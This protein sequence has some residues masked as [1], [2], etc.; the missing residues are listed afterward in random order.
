MSASDQDEYLAAYA[1][2]FAGGLFANKA[3]KR[4]ADNSDV[5][6]AYAEATVRELI[7]KMVHPLR[8]SRGAVIGPDLYANPKSVRQL[9]TIIWSPNPLP[10]IFESGDFALVPRGG[11]CGVIEVKR[12]TYSGA[13]ERMGEFLF[14][15]K[16]LVGAGLCS[17]LRIPLVFGVVCLEEKEGPIDTRLQELISGGK[18]V[19]LLR[20]RK[21]GIEADRDAVR[22][23]VN[24]LQAVRWRAHS[25]HARMFLTQEYSP[26]EEKEV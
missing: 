25:M 2:Q 15:A 12:S 19:V 18:A 10:A 17:L 11:C 23:L 26:Q 14:E 1:Q 22:G 20:K 6:G 24:Y 7:R 5:I 21:R 4:F 16:E 3:I 13:G 9:D 8:V